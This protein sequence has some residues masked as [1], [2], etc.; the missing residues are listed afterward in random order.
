MAGFSRAF[1]ETG[2][3]GDGNG[4]GAAFRRRRRGG[5]ASPVGLALAAD[6]A[7][8]RARVVVAEI[9]RYAEPPN[10]KCNHVAARTMERSAA[11]GWRGSC[12]TRGCPPTIPTTWSFRTAVTGIE[13]ARIHIPGRADALHGTGGP[14]QLV[15]HARAA[16]PH[17]P[18]LSWSPILLAHA[19]ALPGVTMHNRAEVTGFAQDGAC[20]DRRPGLDSGSAGTPPP[21]PRRLRRRQLERAQGDRRKLSRARP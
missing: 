15:A 13:L 21:L 4:P 19:A 17:Q 12:A 14:G 9:R 10:V 7:S 18:D 11:S 20:S 6:L 16:A 2:G 3:I 1:D 5:G 8:R